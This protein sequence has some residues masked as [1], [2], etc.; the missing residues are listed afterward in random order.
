MTSIS[1]KINDEIN[2][3]MNFYDIIPDHRVECKFTDWRIALP[4]NRRGIYVIVEQTLAAETVIYVGRGIIKTRQKMHEHKILNT[5]PGYFKEPEAWKWLR[6][7]RGA[8]IHNWYLIS[9]GLDEK[10]YEAAVEGGLICLLDPLVNDET[11]VG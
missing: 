8:D 2:K 6:T 11:F 10:K 7:E 3:L 4:S 1:Q 9:L 5:L